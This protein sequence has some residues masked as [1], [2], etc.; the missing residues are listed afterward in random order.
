MSDP[1]EV[2][3]ERCVSYLTCPGC[4]DRQ[5]SRS[6]SRTIL[7]GLNMALFQHK[8]IRIEHKQCQE[9]QHA[10]VYYFKVIFF[11]KISR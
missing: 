6:A 1:G 7:N 3:T 2:E 9:I 10:I 4:P 8:R 11:L 5:A